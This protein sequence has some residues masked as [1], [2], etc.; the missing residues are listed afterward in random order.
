MTATTIK[1]VDTLK[2]YLYLAMQLE[3]ATIPPYLTALYSI[4]PQTNSDAYH[5]LRVV[6]VEE[7]LH[8][9]IAANLMNAI[10]GQPDL[11]RDGFMPTYP[12]PLPDGE[13]DF[14]VSLVCF[15]PSAIDTFLKIERP[16]LAPTEEMRWRTTVNEA[17]PNVLHFY[18]IGD[19][20][21]EIKRGFAYLH[22]EHGPALFSGDRDRQVS[23]EYYYSGGGELT[24]V[25]CIDTANA[26]IELIQGQGEGARFGPDDDDRPG[27][28]DREGELA[29]YY[30][31]EQLKIGKY[32]Q[33]GDKP[34]NPTGPECQVDWQAVYPTRTNPRL[35]QF[36]V[37]E[38][39]YEI[40]RAFNR[41]YADFLKLLNRAFNG[42]PQLLL[43]A[44]P[45]MFTLR[46]GV[47]QLVRNPLPGSNAQSDSAATGPRDGPANAAPTFEM[48]EVSG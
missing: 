12:T 13:K 32:Y 31:F 27:I 29:H 8:L 36:R 48:P 14:E 38:E 2:H 35:E 42:K 40:G 17:A 45:G 6:A 18:S 20:Y 39:L 30:R 15:S 16:G 25:V 33:P 22:N 10:G 28:Y 43:E 7:M 3:H 21:E 37:S 23:S 41:D 19:F 34:H 4:H 47:N 46:N 5:V 26:A 1:T 44:V 9:T 11:T 24:P